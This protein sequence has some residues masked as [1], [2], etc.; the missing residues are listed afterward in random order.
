MSLGGHILSGSLYGRM[1]TCQVGAASAAA[2]IT[3]LQQSAGGLW[4]QT[5]GQ[6]RLEAL[7]QVLCNVSTY[8]P[9]AGAAGSGLFCFNTS[10]MPAVHVQ[11]QVDMHVPWLLCI[12]P[13]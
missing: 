4:R 8:V 13:A 12:K 5:G 2:G 7:P 9:A 11:G 1:A 3:A 6:D 10:A